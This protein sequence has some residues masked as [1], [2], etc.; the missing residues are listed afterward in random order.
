MIIIDVEEKIFRS[1][2]KGIKGNPIFYIEK[3]KELEIYAIIN[4]ILFRYIK[5]LPED[6]MENL[7]VRQTYL[8]GAIKIN[9][10]SN[11]NEPEWKIYFN[12]L[13]KLIQIMDLKLD[14]LVN[15]NGE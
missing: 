6:S 2:N 12:N 1:L 11:I 14:E 3:E 8:T 15:K 5:Q 10:I 9:S 7:L 4:Y 13:Y